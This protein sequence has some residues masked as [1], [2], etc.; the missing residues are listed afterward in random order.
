[1]ATTSLSV[2]AAIV[3]GTACAGAFVGAGLYL[4]L[5]ERAVP[6][7][8]SSVATT[9]LV[10]SVAP[11]TTSV[12]V[13]AR[14]DVAPIDPAAAASA[15]EEVK[16]VFDSQHAHLVEKCW[17]PSFA[18]SSTPASTTIV[19]TL[20]FGADGRPGAHSVREDFATTRPEVT[21][22]IVKELVIPAITPP[23]ARTRLDYQLNLP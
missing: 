20:S 10:A 9:G 23:G 6:A 16:R 8:V 19:F 2:P 5:R 1:V 15:R 11:L 7:P 12:P 17:A 14:P 13:G 4:G 22:C 21:S 18:K 3:L